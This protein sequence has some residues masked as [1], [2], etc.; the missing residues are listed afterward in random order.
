VPSNG[1]KVEEVAEAA[2]AK[3]LNDDVELDDELVLVFVFEVV[4][5]PLGPLALFASLARL[6]I[7]HSK[8]GSLKSN[9]VSNPFVL[10]DKVVVVL[11]VVLVFEPILDEEAVVGVEEGEGEG[12]LREAAIQLKCWLGCTG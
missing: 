12:N 11:V 7:G 10:G 9:S 8:F 2:E 5:V 1:D 4:L 6:C 3:E